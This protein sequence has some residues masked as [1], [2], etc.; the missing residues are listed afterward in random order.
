MVMDGKVNDANRWLFVIVVCVSAVL[1][2][3][4]FIV[5][6]VVAARD[7]RKTIGVKPVT[8]RSV[9]NEDSMFRLNGPT[10]SISCRTR[11][12]LSCR[13][14]RDHDRSPVGPLALSLLD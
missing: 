8:P 9:H 7:E 3:L 13:S 6:L 10:V 5:G 14:A 11:N 4:F 2:L 1:W 12:K